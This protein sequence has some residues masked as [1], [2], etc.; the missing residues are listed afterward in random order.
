HS[1][2]LI[3]TVVLTFAF[4]IRP[5]WRGV[6]SDEENMG[7]QCFSDQ[8]EDVG[9]KLTSGAFLSGR[10]KGVNGGSQASNVH[11]GNNKSGTDMRN[12][13]RRLGNMDDKGLNTARKQAGA[14][15]G[16]SLG[17][18]GG[19]GYATRTKRSIN[20]VKDTLNNQADRLRGI[21]RAGRKHIDPSKVKAS[22][23][24]ERGQLVNMGRHMNKIAQTASG[25]GT[26]VVKGA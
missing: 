14:I 17:I 25:L 16:N 5:A 2:A 15:G 1:V 24:V 26:E 3:G 23:L 19:K 12:N 10:G 22:N 21:D 13:A 18:G 9:K 7:G 4:V 8:D 6:M 20:K 11:S